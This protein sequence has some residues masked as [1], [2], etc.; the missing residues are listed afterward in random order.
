MPHG[1]VARHWAELT[2]RLRANKTAPL[3]INVPTSRP[4]RVSTNELTTSD[5]APRDTLKS[6]LGCAAPE[7]TARELSGADEAWQQIRPP[8]R[9]SA[10]CARQSERASR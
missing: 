9:H 1:A 7:P 3:R 2:R 8:I 6:H 10:D 4:K 5:D